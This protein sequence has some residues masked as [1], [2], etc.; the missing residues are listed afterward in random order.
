[1]TDESAQD[2][3]RRFAKA[4]FSRSEAA[5]AEV[6]TEDFE[7]HFAI[8]TDSPDGRVHRGSSQVVAG[9]ERNASEFEFLRFEDVRY[10]VLS[11]TQILMTCRVDGKRREGEAFSVRGLELFTVRD[12]KVAKKDVFW[13]QHS[14]A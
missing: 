13:K 1:M 8:G 12:G 9:I 2:L 5:I 7:W 4:F 3:M 14:A 10:Q 11:S 6:T